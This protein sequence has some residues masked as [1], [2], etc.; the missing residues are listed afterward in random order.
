MGRRIPCEVEGVDIERDDGS[1][2][3]GVEAT[4]TDCD[5]KTHSFGESEASIRRCFA[6]M[7]EQCPQGEDNF[8]I[9]A[10]DAD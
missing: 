5:H 8:Y 6:L 9:N 7:R 4:C 10:E 3:A 2:G 1:L